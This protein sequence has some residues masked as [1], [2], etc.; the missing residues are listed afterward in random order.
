MIGDMPS[1]VRAGRDAGAGIVATAKEDSTGSRSLSK[2]PQLLLGDL[3][4]VR[5]HW[6][7]PRAKSEQ[8]RNVPARTR[9]FSVLH[10]CDRP[11]ALAELTV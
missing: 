8:L 10:L 9:S 7:D 11:R 4:P 1:D 6:N 3:H 2:D 5:R